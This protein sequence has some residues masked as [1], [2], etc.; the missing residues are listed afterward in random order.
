VRE[1]RDDAT[2][3]VWIIFGLIQATLTMLIA[4]DVIHGVAAPQAVTAVT[5]VVYVAVNELWAKPH[6]RRADE[7]GDEPGPWVATTDEAAP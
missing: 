3:W 2:R 7:H 1:L 6:R 5:L 4:F